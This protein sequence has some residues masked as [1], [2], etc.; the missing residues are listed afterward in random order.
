MAPRR[1]GVPG[2]Y[3]ARGFRGA[4]GRYGARG[5]LVGHRGGS[6]P[7]PPPAHSPPAAAPA[8]SA[9]WPW[10]GGGARGGSAVAE[11]QSRGGP[12]PTG[13]LR[14]PPCPAR[15]C[16]GSRPA[17]PPPA[18]GLQE[19]GA[20]GGGGRGP[21]G[22][23]SR[24]GLG[25]R[26]ASAPPHTHTVAA[27]LV[28]RIEAMEGIAA[29]RGVPRAQIHTDSAAGGGPAWGGH[30]GY[31]GW[32]VGSLWAVG[33]HPPYLPPCR[34]WRRTRTP[35]RRRGGSAHLGGGRRRKFW[36]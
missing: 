33:S 10:E 36:G 16:G 3:G 6:P 23:G 28:P 15:G 31:G 9:P 27:V 22:L 13:C 4:Q 14:G 19:H 21:R 17:A 26:G 7:A 30:A 8:P 1:C 35:Q 18:S 25:S 29:H 34:D 20:V 2:C 24:W 32:A 11:I 12:L 5:L